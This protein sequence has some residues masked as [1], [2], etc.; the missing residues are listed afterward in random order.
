MRDFY[1]ILGVS[2]NADE[3][4]LMQAYWKLAGGDEKHLAISGF[5]Q[6]LEELRQAFEILSDKNRRREYDSCL[7]NFNAT[8]QNRSA[9]RYF[10][11]EVCIDFPS[12][13]DIVE[14]MLLDFFSGYEQDLAISSQITLTCHEACNGARVPL[15]LSINC[16]CRNCGGRG[17][18]WMDDCV[19]CKGTGLDTIKRLVSVVVPAGA[20]NGT[21]LHYGIKLPDGQTISVNVDVMVR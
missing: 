13:R 5:S 10:E 15:D 19:S 4:E 21:T 16:C 20:R 8:Y 7:K 9:S 18:I 17:E 12:V 2:E 11:D 1:S 6:P 14:R 3:D